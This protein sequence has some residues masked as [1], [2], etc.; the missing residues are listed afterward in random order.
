[1]TVARRSPFAVRLLGST[2]LTAVALVATLG[3]SSMP[4]VAFG[5]RRP[6]AV[7]SGRSLLPKW[8]GG[9]REDKELRRRVEADGGIPDG[10]MAGK[11]S[12]SG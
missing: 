3:C 7:P 5:P 9:D 12:V 10:P 6:D 1:M 11:A 4:D 8:A 2:L